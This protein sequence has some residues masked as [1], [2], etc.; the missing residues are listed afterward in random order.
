LQ[1]QAIRKKIIFQRKL[2][3]LGVQSF[4]S[5]VGSFDTTPAVPKHVGCTLLQLPLT[6][7]DL[8]RMHVELLREFGQRA[9]ALD[10][11]QRHF[12]L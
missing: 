7:R 11:S 9:L 5:T 10:C 12:S 1:K 4:S 8:I 3:D 2:A 6:L